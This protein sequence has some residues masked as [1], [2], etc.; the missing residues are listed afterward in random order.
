MF[1]P[2]DLDLIK[3]RS[4]G[5]VT[6]PPREGED[7]GGAAPVV[8]GAGG[9]PGVVGPVPA[10]RESTRSDLAPAALGAAIETSTNLRNSGAR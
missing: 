6:D 7:S 5:A 1:N 8:V 4:G 9:A 10:L 3:L 2:L